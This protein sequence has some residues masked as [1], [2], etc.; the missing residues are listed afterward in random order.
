MGWLEED[1][2]LP[3]AKR[4]EEGQRKYV[5]HTCGGGRT[6]VV[7]ADDSGWSG[8]CFRCGDRDWETKI[9]KLHRRYI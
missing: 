8:H 9:T 2:W 6:L 5:D 1:S 3:Y 7:S 4:L